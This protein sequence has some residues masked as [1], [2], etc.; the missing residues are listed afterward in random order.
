M[1]LLDGGVVLFDGSVVLFDGCGLVGWGCGLIG[2]SHIIIDI[3]VG[4]DW[5]LRGRK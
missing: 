2:W 3:I 5:K 4:R 1:V